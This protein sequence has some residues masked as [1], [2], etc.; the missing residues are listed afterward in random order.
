MIQL[1][2]IG[3][4]ID[5]TIENSVSSDYHPLKICILTSGGKVLM[6]QENDQQL[7]RCIFS[8]NRLIFVK[9]VLLNIN[10]LLIVTKDGEAFEGVV[11]ERRKRNSDSGTNTIKSA[12]HKFLD[13]DDCRLVKVVK[14][15]KIHRAVFIESDLEGKNFAVVQVC[16]YYFN[17]KKML[18][19][20]TLSKKFLPNH[21]CF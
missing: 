15:P 2:I 6:W 8:V 17:K 18:Y 16:M 11:K 9:Q 12:F 10:Q 3:G 7:L 20:Y 5:T 14:I 21:F 4:K 1:S 13:K 19:I